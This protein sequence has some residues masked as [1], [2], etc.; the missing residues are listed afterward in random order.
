MASINCALGLQLQNLY[1]Q[2]RAGQ[3][4]RD[5]LVSLQAELVTA[6]AQ[7]TLFRNVYLG[8]SAYR[9][10]TSPPPPS[11]PPVGAYAPPAPPAQVSLGERLEQLRE[12][13]E[14]LEV[15]VVEAAAAIELCVPSATNTCGRSS[16]LAPNPWIANDGQACAGNGT[17]EAIEGLYCGYWNSPVN[18]DAAEVDEAVELLS[19]DGAPYCFSNTGTALKCPV[20]ADRTNRAGVHELKVCA[21]HSN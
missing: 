6:R 14:L 7:Y 13:V 1:E 4:Q 10:P 3:E 9:P 16:L 20:T 15:S 2:D 11:P 8:L 19:E 12:N 17:Y 18:P 5:R 21:L